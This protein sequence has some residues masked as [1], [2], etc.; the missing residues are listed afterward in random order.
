MLFTNNALI[1]SS[2]L[3][4]TL[5]LFC[6]EKN[7][8]LFCVGG[9][10]RDVLLSGLKKNLA[11]IVLPEFALNAELDFT[12]EAN[13][14]AVAQALCQWRTEFECVQT[15]PAFGTATLRFKHKLQFDLASTRTERYAYPGALPTVEQLGVPLAQDALRR[16]FTMNT[17][18]L[19]L[20]VAE[21]LPEAREAWVDPTG[22]GL[23]DLNARQLRVLH[24]DSFVEDPSR[25][26]RGFGF[27]SR[28]AFKFEPQTWLWLKRCLSTFPEP[29]AP[30]TGGGERMRVALYKWLASDAAA[31]QTQ[32]KLEDWMLFLNTGG[33]VLL[34][35]PDLKTFVPNSA[36]NSIRAVFERLFFYHQQLVSGEIGAPEANACEVSLPELCTPESDAATMELGDW[37]AQESNS[38]GGHFLDKNNLDKPSRA[39]LRQTLFMACVLA[40]GACV[41]PE[42]QCALQNGLALRRDE[43]Q[44]VN[45]LAGF[46]TPENRVALQQALAKKNAAAVCALLDAVRLPVAL[47]CFV[48]LPLFERFELK[49]DRPD[50]PDAA[51]QACWLTFLTY[52]RHWRRVA[53]PLQ[54]ADLLALGV[55]QGP[56]IQRLQTQL[57]LLHL[58]GKITDATAAKAWLQAQLR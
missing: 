15:Y 45:Q 2:E 17:L 18:A 53:S 54:P 14:L 5:N 26:V 49:A 3:L 36:D 21:A 12:V 1:Q 34:G 44:Q 41:T 7:L 50:E 4:K 38:Q 48:H 11:E 32:K 31:H 58:E 13:A 46:N 22:L 55:P 6:A 24:A 19:R 8:T 27:C 51:A 47:A 23:N 29:N 56:E 57:R 10:P 33:A 20:P 25:I 42:Q 43:R 16:D 52:W 30:Y 39:E 37:V 40:L 28:F 9:F 35:G